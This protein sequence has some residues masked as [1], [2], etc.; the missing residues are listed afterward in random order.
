MM[1]NN[2][3]GALT[4][5]ALLVAF[6]V[7]FLLQNF[8]L[9]GGLESLIWLVLFGGGG[10]AFLYVFASNQQQWWAVIPGFVLLGLGMLIGFGDRLGAWG[11]ALFLGSIG[12][13]FWVIYFVRRDFWW[14]VIP[15]GVLL[16]LAAVA[17]L[18]D[19]LPGL[20]TGGIFFLGLALTFALVYLLP[21]AEG[22]QRWAA[23][24]ALVLGVMGLLLTLSLGG[25]INY[26]WAIGLIVAGV[27]LLTRSRLFQR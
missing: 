14:A 15:G 3:T 12:L 19:R 7:L 22:R 23:I 26:A 13:A 24:P 18:G 2:R 1:N 27:Y 17:A 25:L 4:V 20:A 8:G 11:G 5:G 10:L 21:A 9:F 6:G 16:T